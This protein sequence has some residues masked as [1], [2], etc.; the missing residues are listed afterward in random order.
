M[1]LALLWLGFFCSTAAWPAADNN[2]R[3]RENG[4]VLGELSRLSGVS[5][6]EALA[7]M[8]L[9]IQ[10]TWLVQDYAKAGHVIFQARLNADLPMAT[11]DRRLKS[12]ESVD[13]DLDIE[14]TATPNGKYRI[15]L[16][17]SLGEVELIH[18]LKRTF[19]ASQDFKSFSDTPVRAR[20]RNANLTNYRSYLLRQIGALKAQI[21]QS[22][23]Y[24]SVYVG[25]QTYQGRDVHVIRTYKPGGRKVV[26]NKKGPMALNKLWTF[27]HDG[28]YEIW[29][30]QT[31]KLPAVVFYTNLDDDVYANFTIDYDRYWMPSRISFQNNSL[32]AEGSGDLVF[33]FDRDR[34]LTGISLK[35]LGENGVALHLDATLLFGG[36]PLEDAFRIIPP[37]GFRKLNR[38]HLKL[39]LLTQISGGLLKLK[40]HG[41]NIKNF[42]F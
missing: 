19:V 14:G 38:D 9:A 31:T 36:A 13:F 12:R 16:R 35:F 27:W 42:K 41:F 1:K 5:A 23:S 30:Y 11:L 10:R 20:S 24:Q 26:K 33:Q 39:M 21:L 32:G 18:D 15:E 7:E 28:G 40:K 37:F 4:P 2:D 29:I 8:F 34:V 17:G 22:G 6:H 3:A 25:S